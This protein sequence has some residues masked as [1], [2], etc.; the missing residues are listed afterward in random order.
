MS[1]EHDFPGTRRGQLATSIT[2]LVDRFGTSDSPHTGAFM[3][4]A[5]AGPGLAVWYWM[6]GLPAY[7]G[8]AWATLN[9][10]GILAWVIR[11]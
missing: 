7:A 1:D 2:T 3:N 5:L 4:L 10:A 8:L 9:L 6:S 11:Q